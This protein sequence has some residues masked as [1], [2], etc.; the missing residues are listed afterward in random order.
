MHSHGSGVH[1]H[2]SGEENHAARPHPEHVVLDIGEDLGALIVYTDAAM[3]GVEIEISPRGEDDR[4]SHKDVLERE[5]NGR[6]AYT[7]V[8]DK[9]PEGTYTLWVDD[10]A[11]ARNVAIS[12]G[13]IA[14][15]DWRGA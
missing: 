6:P 5:I 2:A 3:L 15:L 14:E 1:A 13:E 12:G 10:T 8:F 7:A 9:V 4:R 11:R